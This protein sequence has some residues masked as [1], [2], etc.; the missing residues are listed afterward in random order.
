MNTLNKVGLL[1]LLSFF[2]QGAAADGNHSMRYGSSS[3]RII[4]SHES[5]G[6]DYLSSVGIA[7][8][9][10]DSES[11]FGIELGTSLGNAEVVSTDGYLEDYVAWEGNMRLGYFSNISIFVEAGF[12][13]TEA[14]FEDERYD[15]HH[16]DYLYHDD[17]DA[18]VGFGIGLNAGPFQIDGFVRNREIDS[19]YWE[20]QS[21]VFSGVQFSFKF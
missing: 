6:A 20:A 13:L 11:K 10:K 21:E 7:T 18:Y 15:D 1:A 9:L 4:Y 2:S 14:I 19:L 17:I 16:D 5:N 3:T 12:D 8:L